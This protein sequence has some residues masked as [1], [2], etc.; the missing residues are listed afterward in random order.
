MKYLIALTITASG[1]CQNPT[2]TKLP[3]GSGRA[4]LERVCTPCHGL[5][6]VVRSRMTKEKWAG[7]VDNMVSRGAQG[8]EDDF[9]RII[10]YLAANFGPDTKREEKSPR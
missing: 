7:V 2:P 10:N 6:N 9:D 5:D 1:F 8:T 3:E 4:Q